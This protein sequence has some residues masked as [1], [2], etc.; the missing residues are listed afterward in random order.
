M[1]THRFLRASHIVVKFFG[2]FPIRIDYNK[3]EQLATPHL[4][5]FIY[6]IVFAVILNGFVFYSFSSFVSSPV[7]DLNQETLLIALRVER[8]CEFVH[9]L[10]TYA[11]LWFYRLTMTE[12]V[13]MGESIHRKLRY[14]IRYNERYDAEYHRVVKQ[15]YCWT[16]IQSVLII[17]TWVSYTV[18]S[19]MGFVQITI[20]VFCA[21]VFTVIVTLMQFSMMIEVSQLYRRLN[22]KLSACVYKIRQISCLSEKNQM[23]MQMFCDVSDDIDEVASIYKCIT[24]CNNMVC[25]VLALSIMANVVN[26]FTNLLIGVNCIC[27]CNN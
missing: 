6:S 18:N 4:T 3:E 9:N 8:F 24:K 13:N 17:C 15:V 19:S 23:K 22:G 2:L 14:F 11:S 20:I 26:T 5:N 1:I 27:F 21:N 10:L 16:I 7:D 25:R 12:C